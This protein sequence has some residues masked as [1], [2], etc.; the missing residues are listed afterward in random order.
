MP[1]DMSRAEWRERVAV[2]KR[3]AQEVRLEQ[4]G[5][6]VYK[7]PSIEDQERLASER[8]LNDDSLQL[9]DIVS[10]NR[11][12]FLFKGKPDRE[13]SDSDFVLLQPR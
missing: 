8:V 2:A 7:A 6:A 10:T 9:G 5:R 4:R 12:L 1:L 13:R 3:R 11:G